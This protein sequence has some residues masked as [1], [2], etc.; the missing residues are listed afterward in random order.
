MLCRIEADVAGKKQGMIINHYL[1][2]D[3]NMARDHSH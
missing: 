3:Y 1:E 2:E